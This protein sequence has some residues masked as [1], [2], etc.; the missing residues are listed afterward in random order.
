MIQEDWL[1][2]SMSSCA[3]QTCKMEGGHLG[4]FLCLL[5][6]DLGWKTNQEDCGIQMINLQENQALKQGA[7]IFSCFPAW[8]FSAI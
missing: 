6:I 1:N 2:V 3:S 4:V 5:D 8:F 7:F